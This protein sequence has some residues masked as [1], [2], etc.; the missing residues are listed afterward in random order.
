MKRSKT[1]RKPYKIAFF[2]LIGVILAGIILIIGLIFADGQPAPANHYSSK[3]GIDLTLN[4]NQI[5][6]LADVY[7]TKAQKTQ[8]D[9]VQYRF[10]LQGKNGIV[11]GKIKLLGADVP[12]ALE[13]SPA[14]TENGDIE[15]H[16]NKLSIGRQSLPLSLVLL[17]VKESYHF[18]DWV[19]I[20]PASKQVYLNTTNLNGKDGLNFKATKIDMNGAGKFK[21]K[22]LL[23]AR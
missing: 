19:T 13:F 6:E 14:V 23:P 22:I 7:L 10:Q 11:Y 8:S 5:N 9:K 17:Y 1:Q 16:A 18:P 15:L 3:Q 4:K 12:Y 20:N 21:F 2:T